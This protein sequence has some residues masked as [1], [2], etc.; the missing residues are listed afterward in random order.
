[1]NLN[2]LPTIPEEIGRLQMTP[3]E[4]FGEIKATFRPGRGNIIAGIVIGFILILGGIGLGL[5]IAFQDTPHQQQ[6]GDKTGKY[7][8]SFGFGIGGIFIFRWMRRLLSHQVVVGENGFAYTER[9]I[10]DVCL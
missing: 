3:I 5:Y 8:A 7:V 2:E 9:G 10:T 4:A 6:T 1:V